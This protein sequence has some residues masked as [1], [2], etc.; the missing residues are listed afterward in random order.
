MSELENERLHLKQVLQQLDERKQFVV[1]KLESVKRMSDLDMAKTVNE[2]YDREYFNIKKHYSSPYFAKIIYKDDKEATDDV[3]YIG[4]VGFQD[5]FS[6]EIVVDWRAPVASLY[7]NSEVGRASYHSPEGV[8]EGELK[9]KRHTNIENCFLKDYTDSDS[10]T[11]DELLKPYLT[12]S[13]DKRL[14]SIVATIQREQNE[15]IRAPKSNIIVQGVAG[16]GKTTVALHRLS[17]LI[18][19][20]RKFDSTSDFMIIAPNNLFLN[21]ISQVLPELDT[22]NVSQ[23]T[24]EELTSILVKEKFKILNKNETLRKIAEGE[25]AKWYLKLK[26]SLDYKNLLDEFWAKE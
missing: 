22:G 14:K 9:L 20:M 24:I 1:D 4:K 16:S 2:I 8:K 21:Y 10:M 6:N 23:L 26:T 25:E 3:M 19:Q 13:A 17:Y 15:I 18:Y 7:Y 5:K 12:V 11:N